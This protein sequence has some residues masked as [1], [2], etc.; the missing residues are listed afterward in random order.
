MRRIGPCL[1]TPTRNTQTPHTSP[2]NLSLHISPLKPH[3]HSFHRHHILLYNM[4]LQLQASPLRLQLQSPSPS[5]KNGLKSPLNYAIKALL[6]A[7]V[8]KS[9]DYRPFLNQNVILTLYS[10]HIY[11]AVEILLAMSVLPAR[12]IFKFEIEPQFNDPYRTTSL[13]D[14]WGRRWNLMVTG[15]LRPTVYLPTRG[16]CKPRWQ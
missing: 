15:I 1:Q 14:F 6:L 8:I 4:S 13:Q 5:P 10:L 7:L 2:H 9:Y 12:S 16:I 11:L 3:L